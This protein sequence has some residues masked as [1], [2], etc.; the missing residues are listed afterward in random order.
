[1]VQTVSSAGAAE[2][3]VTYREQ[4][5]PPTLAPWVRCLWQL[6]VQ[7]DGGPGWVVPD[8]VIDLVASGPALHLAGPDTR[9]WPVRRRAGA[10][11][12]GARFHP[13]AAPALLGPP[14][15]E[16]RD[17]RVAPDALWGR[18]GRELAERVGAAASPAARLEAMVA[19]LSDRLGDAAPPDPGDPDGRRPVGRRRHQQVAGEPA[20]VGR[21]PGR[22]AALLGEVGEAGVGHG[23]AEQARPEQQHG[24]AADADPG[25]HHEHDRGQHHVPGR[26]GEDDRLLEDA[27]LPAR[28]TGPSTS[29]QLVYSSEVATTAPS[30]G[31]RAWR[32]ARSARPG[33]A[34]MA[35]AARG[36]APR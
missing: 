21:H 19:G 33:K 25:H 12:V 10:V 18:A 1:M 34:S 6:T 36:M 31:D 22:V 35:A 20:D 3:A 4:A 24:G 17:T 5:P 13:G 28:N 23:Q 8:G 9:P 27:A 2:T 29:A 30:S 32:V 7:G 15:S 14:A 16:L 26:V 11:A